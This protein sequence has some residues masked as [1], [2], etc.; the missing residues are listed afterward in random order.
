MSLSNSLAL[1]CLCGTAAASAGGVPRT[2]LF[3]GDGDAVPMRRSIVGVN[4]LAYGKDGYGLLLHGSHDPDPELVAL[5]KKIGFGSLRYPGGCG[6]THDFVWKKN[7]GL[8]GDYHVLG[9]VEFMDM[10]EKVGAEP[11]LGVSAM[12][13]TPQEAAEFVEF[14]N[15]PADGT[16]PWAEK[17]A[18]RGRERPWNAVWFEYG[19]E[20]YHGSHARNGEKPRHI[21]AES[22]AD[23]YI[24]FREAMRKADP[25]V[26]LGLALSGA[27]STAWDRCVLSRA[28]AVA[29]FVVMHTYCAVPERDDQDGFLELFEG[30]KA[31][32]GEMLANA[33]SAI[34]RRGTP[35]A[36][37]EFNAT[38]TTFKTLAAALVNAQTLMTLAADSRVAH[39]DYWQFV[40]EGFGM[41]RGYAG[42]FV[43]RPNAL[44]FGLYARCTLDEIFP[45]K[46][47]A[48]PREVSSGAAFPEELRGR[49][50]VERS[51]FR[52]ENG[53]AQSTGT[54]IESLPDGETRLHFLDDR[55][56]NFY[57]AVIRVNNLPRGR[58]CDWRLSCELR[59][60]GR[61]NSGF[62]VD[63]GD[64][65]GW[66]V[67]R[68]CI[69]T[70]S[71]CGTDWIPASCTYAPLKDTCSLLIRIRREGAG[72][73]TA[74][75][76]N[77]RV[78][79]VERNSLR[80]V[81]VVDAQLSR[82]S[83]GSRTAWFILNRSLV[84]Q[85]AALPAEGAATM[86]ESLVGPTAY[87]SNEQS[88]D[89][90][91][92]VS[93]DVRRDGGRFLLALPPH[94]ATGFMMSNKPEKTQESGRVESI[95][96]PRR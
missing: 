64:G 20:T 42:A 31:F 44:A 76:R 13:G 3:Q 45:V 66:N 83:D 7:A 86:A 26:K 61:A 53:N 89:A 38:Y 36:I 2:E 34:P 70:A 52:Y 37:T 49:N 28:G 96:V 1:L 17:R 39:A 35:I 93:T 15:A 22:Y 29:D 10:C 56:L 21:S 84:A 51:C 60:D 95:G 59:T 88:P 72:A 68:S 8:M 80:N 63:I 85:E 91:R 65:R 62:Y 75:V 55:Q 58:V 79:A 92:I 47:V 67:T 43:Q 16:R 12:R 41:V 46:V 25:R 14:L 74:C 9:V 57:H 69:G 87:A 32:L 4:H 78:E 50:L 24:A 94:S 27:G 30:R 81:P 33:A 40:N 23:G 19:N 54:R 90:V 48:A 82:S 18:A 77:L 73:D 6:G 11:M 71:A 5:Q